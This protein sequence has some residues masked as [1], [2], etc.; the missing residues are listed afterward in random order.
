MIWIG[1]ALLVLAFTFFSY[2]LWRDYG[3]LGV[4]LY[5]GLFG[6]FL[7]AGFPVIGGA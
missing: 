3:W 1:T 2:A 7:T 6:L 4:A 5:W